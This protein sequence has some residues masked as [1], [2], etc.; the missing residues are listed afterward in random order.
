MGHISPPFYWVVEKR[1]NIRS[2]EPKEKREAMVSG[3]EI[4][5]V[6][7]VS[8]K[9]VSVIINIINALNAIRK[10]EKIINYSLKKKCFIVL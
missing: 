5:N 1:K 2:V 7:L 6:N 8:V 10:Q 4:I 3:Q 9:H